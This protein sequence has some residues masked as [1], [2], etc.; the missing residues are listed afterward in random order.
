MLQIRDA[1]RKYYQEDKNAVFNTESTAGINEKFKKIVEIFED[2][3]KKIQL[4]QANHPA[5]VEIM[6]SYS[7]AHFEYANLLTH[8]GSIPSEENEENPTISYTEDTESYQHL[9]K[10]YELVQETESMALH[11]VRSVGSATTPVVFKQ[12]Y[13][14]PAARGLASVKLMKARIELEL[15]RRFDLRPKVIQKYYYVFIILIL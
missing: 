11:L 7:Q 4:Y 13:S 15:A 14:L 2:T 6:L 8:K 5:S 9:R 12:S 1:F 10:S 3:R